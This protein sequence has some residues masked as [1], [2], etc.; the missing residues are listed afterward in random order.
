MPTIQPLG[1]AKI[2][3]PIPVPRRDEPLR[4]V[5][6]ARDW[7]LESMVRAREASDAAVMQAASAL[8]NALAPYGEQ[9]QVEIPVEL[10]RKLADFA[11]L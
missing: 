6:Q 11:A 8:Y 5:T 4:Y 10:H 7:L 3:P 2:V 9:P 1:G